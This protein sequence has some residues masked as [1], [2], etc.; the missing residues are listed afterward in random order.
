MSLALCT[1]IINLAALS[2]KIEMHGHQIMTR[3][4]V[5]VEG[6][7]KVPEESFTKI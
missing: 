5:T 1:A 6:L 2:S 4:S 7:S 3:V